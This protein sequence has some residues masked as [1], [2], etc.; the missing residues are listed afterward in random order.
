[1]NPATISSEFWRC[2]VYPFNPNAIDCSVS[3]AN[4]EGSLQEVN[5]SKSTNQACDRKSTIPSERQHFSNEGMKKSMT[6][7]MMSI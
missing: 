2:G 7:M 3:V 5:K 1:M 6:Y 4:P